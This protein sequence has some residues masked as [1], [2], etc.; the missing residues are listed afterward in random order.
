MLI[1]ALLTLVALP[2]VPANEFPADGYTL[3]RS[4]SPG[5][6][7]VFGPEAHAVLTSGNRQA[8]AVAAVATP[9]KGRIFAIAHNGYF[10]PTYFE[11]DDGMMALSLQWLRGD[12]KPG[13]V[14]FLQDGGKGL[15]KTLE[16][17]GYSVVPMPSTRF[18]DL[19]LL[20]VE[21][22]GPMDPES[23]AA[24][25][26][27]ILE[28]GT[29][30]AAICPWGWQQIHGA[31]G[32]DL[33][34]DM[35]ANQIMAPFGLLFTDGYATP[36]SGNEF[37]VDREA[38]AAVN[39]QSLVAQIAKAEIPASLA[40]LESALRVLPMNDAILLPKLMPLLPSLDAERSPT[41]KRP[42]KV[43]DAPLARL[44][45]IAVDRKLRNA[46][47][48]AP[49]LAPGAFS[50]PGVTPKGSQPS[51][52]MVA[53]DAKQ[54]GWQSTGRYVNPGGVVNLTFPEGGELGWS[55]RIGAHADQ[56]WHKDRW[57][58]WPSVSTTGPVTER[59]T[60][61]FGG[62]LYFQKKSDEARSVN[63]QVSG[64]LPAPYWK[65]GETTPEMW[66]V[67]RNAQAP[68]AELEGQHLILTVPSA[69]VRELKD[70]EALMAYW[71]RVVSMQHLFGGEEP[72]ARPERFV[73]DVL[74]SAG[75][76]HAG[77]PIMMHLDVAEPRDSGKKLSVL[78]DLE[79]L[80]SKGNWGCFHELGH[81]RQKPSWTF[82]G[83]GEVTNNLFS[84]Y[85]GQMSAGIE[86]WENPWLQNQKKAGA[87]YLLDGP[88]FAIWKRQPGIAL[89]CYAQIQ[90]H[91][92]WEPFR[93]TFAAAGS[94]PKSLQPKNDAAKQTF[95]VRQMSLATQRD[96]RPF[97]AHWGWPLEDSLI[98]DEHLDTLEPWMPDFED[99]KK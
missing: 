86:P 53:C 27:W 6:I 74:I 50:F 4:G 80:Q 42:L 51:T 60:S 70:P 38:C 90:R 33:T 88:D 40:P 14:A 22:A 15:R 47:P 10:N 44:A 92:G 65:S 96:L 41:P 48:D 3:S 49:L 20:V 12:S 89:L 82:G 83:T 24:I 57:P 43:N 13:Q 69:A 11:E 72:P 45:V 95:W 97:H 55:Y 71:D 31:D 76:M 87:R 94:L 30:L 56:L 39:C 35:A 62:L 58:R 46:T 23:L 85:S 19:Q 77:Y 37:V 61:P 26:A 79:E 17:D 66:E 75:Y 91:F 36:S 67:L 81:N 99:L 16:Q 32:W 9:G 54:S 93:R 21:G 64:A 25:H 28:G 29:V 73:A 34:T 84:L 59:I 78:L 2:Q 18:D 5:L 63:I 8:Q 7:C 98:H 1:A 52:S 68:W